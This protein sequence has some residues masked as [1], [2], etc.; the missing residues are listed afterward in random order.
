MRKILAIAGSLLFFVVAPG[1]VAGLVPWFIAGMPSGADVTSAHGAPGLI[2]IVLGLIPLV[3]SFLRFALKG[4]GTPAPIAPTRHLVVSGFYRHLRNPMYT[5]VIAI[6]VGEALLFA[7]WPLVLY[8]VGVALAMHLFVV[9]YEERKLERTFGAE[10][11]TFRAYVPRWLPRI[12]P[13]TG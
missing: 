5:G 6:L 2:L 12:T 7:S 10:Y 3:E 9:L 13:W 4:L 11:E 8:A 1:T